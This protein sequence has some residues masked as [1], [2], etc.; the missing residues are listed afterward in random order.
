MRRWGG[1]VQCCVW[2]EA[3]GKRKGG[4]GGC[5][6]AKWGRKNGIKGGGGEEARAE[7]PS[8]SLGAHGGGGRRR[9]GV[10]YFAFEEGVVVAPGGVPSR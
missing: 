9:G 1:G 2:P 6:C 5:G 7:G 4:E 8:L 3:A 10:M